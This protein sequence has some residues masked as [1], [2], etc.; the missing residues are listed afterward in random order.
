ME[1]Q[2]GFQ[3]LIPRDETDVEQRSKP[4]DLSGCCSEIIESETGDTLWMDEDEKPTAE[5]TLGDGCQV[6]FVSV[7]GI[8]KHFSPT[9]ELLVHRD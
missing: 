6:Q 1:G 2:K 9:G 3:H 8:D 7:V 5:I 4:A